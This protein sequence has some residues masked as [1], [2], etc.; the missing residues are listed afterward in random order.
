M[1]NKWSVAG[2][3]ICFF[4][5]KLVE[6]DDFKKYKPPSPPGGMYIIVGKTTDE[7]IEK[8]F[9]ELMRE[10]RRI[11]KLYSHIQEHMDAI[12]DMMS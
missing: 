5:D 6:P 7:I 4:H 3:V 2:R 8:I 10:S 9:M 12:D 11:D 1:L